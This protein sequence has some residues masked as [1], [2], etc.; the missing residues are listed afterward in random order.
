MA[1]STPSKPAIED[2]SRHNFSRLL[3]V[4]IAQRADSDRR[5]APCI[6]LPNDVYSDRFKQQNSP[7]FRYYGTVSQ[8]CKL[9][10]ITGSSCH[11]SPFQLTIPPL[12]ILPKIPQMLG[13]RGAFTTLTS[14]SCT[15]HVPF[16]LLTAS[17]IECR[18]GPRL[19]TLWRK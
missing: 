9:L 10:T 17:A 13:F 19:E 6:F 11:R 18:R 4:T 3:P 2:S 8:Q 12:S 16:S 15:L 5:R 7:H 14:A 1:V